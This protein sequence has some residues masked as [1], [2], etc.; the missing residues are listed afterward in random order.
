MI[1][2]TP[3]IDAVLLSCNGGEKHAVLVQI[4]IAS[5]RTNI[6]NGVRST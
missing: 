4:K 6:A 5:L 2:R 1:K 3:G